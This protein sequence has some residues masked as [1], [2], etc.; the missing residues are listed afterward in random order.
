VVKMVVTSIRRLLQS[1]RATPDNHSWK[2][3]MT[4]LVFSCATNYRMLARS[5]LSSGC[6]Y[7]S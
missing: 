3:A 7:L 6:A 4:A 5:Q 2:C 1:G